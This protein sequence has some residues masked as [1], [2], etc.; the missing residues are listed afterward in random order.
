MQLP[1][2]AYFSSNKSAKKNSSKKP[3]LAAWHYFNGDIPFI[4][5]RRYATK[6]ITE[7]Q[8]SDT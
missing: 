1:Q 6:A 5:R 4:G 2:N 8:I 3:T 7:N